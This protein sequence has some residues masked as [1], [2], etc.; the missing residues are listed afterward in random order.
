MVG[1]DAFAQIYMPPLLSSLPMKKDSPL[2]SSNSTQVQLFGINQILNFAITVLENE[3]CTHCFY[4][5]SSTHLETRSYISTLSNAF[6]LLRKEISL[7]IFSLCL[8]LSYPYLRGASIECSSLFN[9]VS[10]DST[11][12][13]FIII[14][15]YCIS[16]T[17]YHPLLVVLS[18]LFVEDSLT[19]NLLFFKGKNYYFLIAIKVYR[20]LAEPFI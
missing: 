14:S 18:F 6:P 12:S 3:R 11:S 5:K 19:P 15:Y 7:S 8:L 2:V 9:D 10:L 13:Y 4:R 1:F 16:S 20:P 17:F